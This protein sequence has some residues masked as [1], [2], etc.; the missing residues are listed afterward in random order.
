MISVETRFIR[1][2]QWT[3]R[4]NLNEDDQKQGKEAKENDMGMSGVVTVELG[5]CRVEDRYIYAFD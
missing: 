2:I 3:L 4:P 1:Q 5:C